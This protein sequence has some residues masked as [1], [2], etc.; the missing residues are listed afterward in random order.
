MV[1]RDNEIKELHRFPR[2]LSRKSKRITRT[3]MP[4][5]ISAI[6]T[7]MVFITGL[8][9][10]KKRRTIPN[11]TIPIEIGRVKS[12]PNA[13]WIKELPGISST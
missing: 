8:G 1:I 4:K 6:H 2:G 3:I 7:G 9:A 11:R 10:A 12:Q 13:K 5:L